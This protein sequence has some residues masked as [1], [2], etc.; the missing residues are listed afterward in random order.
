MILTI[1]FQYFYL[2]QYLSVFLISLLFILYWYLFEYSI[3]ILATISLTLFGYVSLSFLKFFINLSSPNNRNYFQ[4]R[5][6][7]FSSD[8]IESYFEEEYYSKIAYSKIIKVVVK[9]NYF[10]LFLNDSNYYYVPKSSFL[11]SGEIQQFI[12][13]LVDLSLITGSSSTSP[14]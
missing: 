11:N 2:R 14:N 9:K 12:D 13:K 4:K 10:L 7:V 6:F 8:Y 3:Q 5:F 1:S